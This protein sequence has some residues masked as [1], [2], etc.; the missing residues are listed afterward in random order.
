MFSAPENTPSSSAQKT[1]RTPPRIGPE[2]PQNRP[3]KSRPG[4]APSTVGA[5]ARRVRGE[6][7]RDVQKTIALLAR[8]IQVAPERIAALLARGWSVGV[9]GSVLAGVQEHTAELMISERE[10]VREPDDADLEDEEA[11]E[12]AALA[13]ALRAFDSLDVRAP[14]TF[15][16]LVTKLAADDVH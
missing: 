16:E 2:D 9:V 10:R 14:C 11:H 1:P 4:A 15:G 13:F 5:G 8:R 7:R 6:H 12:R 3:R